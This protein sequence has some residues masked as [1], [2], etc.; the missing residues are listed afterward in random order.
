MFNKLVGV[1]H[2]TCSRNLYVSAVSCVQEMCTC[3]PIPQLKKRVRV[4]HY[5]CSRNMYMSA[6]SCVQIIC[7]CLTL[8]VSEKLSPPFRMHHTILHLT[9]LVYRYLMEWKF[10]SI[11]THFTW[12][13]EYVI[14]LNGLHLTKSFF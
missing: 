14:I 8:P 12:P 6:I 11:Q 5:M 7:T 13:S 3:P 4:R 9:F 1:C 2:Y 10:S